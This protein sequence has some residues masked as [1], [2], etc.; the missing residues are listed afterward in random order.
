MSITVMVSLE[1][2]DFDAWKAVFDADSDNREKA[3]IRATPYKDMDNPNHVHVIG[4]APSKESFLTFFSN[5][6]L[7]ERIKKSGVQSPP[8]IKFLKNA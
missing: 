4:T 3:G 1:V 8:E 2:A 5:P 6:E 7:Q